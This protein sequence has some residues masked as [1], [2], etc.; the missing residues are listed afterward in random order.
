M[1]CQAVEELLRASMKSIMVTM[2][3]RGDQFMSSEPHSKA[4]T[5]RAA[6]IG[7]GLAG[8]VFHAPLIAATPGMKVA[9]IVTNNSERRQRAQRD[10]PTAAVLASA[11]EIW[12]APER[13]D[14]VVVAS[15]N[16][17]HVPLAMA[18]MEAGIPV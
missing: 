8:S 2:R 5:L 4:T 7:Y 15:T 11:D 16:R 14:L 10:F 3:I 9:A 1:L 13:Y 12:Q 6:I 18:A 17:F